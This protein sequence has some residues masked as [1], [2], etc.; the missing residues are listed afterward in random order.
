MNL[1]QRL[2]NFGRTSPEKPSSSSW[3]WPQFIK[4]RPV[5][6]DSALTYSAL[7]SCVRVISETLASLP[8]QTYQRTKRGR[9]DAE[10]SDVGWLLKYAPNPEQTPFI[11]KELLARRALVAGNGYAEIQRDRADRPVALWPI[12][13]ERIQPDRDPDTREIIY[14]VR[15]PDGEVILRA[16]DVYHLKGPGGDGLTGYSPIRLAASAI[17]LGTAMED[18]GNAFFANGANPGIAFKHPKALGDAARDNLKRSLKEKTGGR[19]ALSPIVLEEGMDVTRIGIPPEEAQFLE[20]RRWQILEIARW[21]RVPP[22]K[23][24][25]LERATWS[26]IEQ[27]AIEFVTDCIL[28]W[29]I[30]M[31]EEANLKLFGRNNRGVYYT[32]LNIAGILRGDLKTRYEAY[33]IGRQWGWLNANMI[34]EMEDMNPIPNGNQFIVPSNFTTPQKLAADPIQTPAPPMPGA[35]SQTDEDDDEDPQDAFRRTLKAKKLNG[36]SHHA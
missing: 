16:R 27:Q 33:A 11:F 29:A 18:F 23:L 22:H 36:K 5:T 7:W 1:L 31:E 4:L 19:N 35:D 17:A 2:L 13:T 15:D 8:W 20:S 30:R 32:K 12:C 28:P 6:E 14:R 25:E 34:L 9:K 24:A 26:N 10:G 21:Y 3:W